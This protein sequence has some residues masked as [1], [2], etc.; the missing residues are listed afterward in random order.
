MMEN[1]LFKVEKE[2]LKQTQSS[3]SIIAYATAIGCWLGAL[4]NSI[5]SIIISL[6]APTLLYLSTPIAT[7][8]AGLVTIWR[9]KVMIT[10]LQKL[11]EMEQKAPVV[12]G[13]QEPEPADD[14]L[15]APQDAD[16]II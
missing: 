12:P 10:K 16:E 5:C 4:V 14:S 13:P 15:L 8:I 9:A 2:L 11:D 3:I 6:T 1:L 7:A